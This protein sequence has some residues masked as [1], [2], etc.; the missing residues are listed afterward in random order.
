VWKE[1]C[2]HCQQ[3]HLSLSLSE[4]EMDISEELR[5]A[6]K[7][8]FLE[9]LDQD[10]R[11]SLSFSLSLSLSHILDDGDDDDAGR[12]GHIHG[13]DQGHDKPQAPPPRRQHLRSP[14]LSQLGHQVNLLPISHL[15]CWY[16]LVS[17]IGEKN[18]LN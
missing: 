5:A 15:I 14:L 11:A 9:F 2:H 3:L 13:R 17:K 1:G 18:R 7:R 4:A 12:E 16:F 6:H 8:E 10:V